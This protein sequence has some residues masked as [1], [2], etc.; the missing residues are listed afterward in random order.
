MPIFHT[1]EA[2]ALYSNT[3]NNH[4]HM[5][6]HTHAYTHTHRVTGEG[7]I[8]TALQKDSLEMVLI[9]LFP[10]R[11]RCLQTAWSRLFGV[12][13]VTP[14]PRCDR[15]QPI[16]LTTCTPTSA[17]GRWM[18]SCPISYNSWYVI[19]S[20]S[21]LWPPVFWI[22]FFNLLLINVCCSLVWYWSFGQNGWQ[23]QPILAFTCSFSRLSTE[24]AHSW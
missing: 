12:H 6:A 19:L 11:C 2:R 18:R 14:C 17:S 15:W 7:G 21:S 24:G 8:D 22:L 10:F 9:G 3:N 4:T 16:P 23:Y 1:C 13:C 20:H 5:H